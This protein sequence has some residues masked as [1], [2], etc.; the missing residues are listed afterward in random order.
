MH[1]GALTSRRAFL[2]GGVALAAS[3]V[4][5][6]I[7]Y[8]NDNAEVVPEEVYG[9]NEWLELGDAFK[10]STEVD[11]RGY[12]FMVTNLE[13]MTPNEYLQAYSRDGVTA[14]EGPDADT[15]CVL[16]LS[17]KVRNIGNEE[18]GIKGYLWKMVPEEQNNILFNLDDEL[19][20]HGFPEFGGG[21]AF[22]V[23][24]GEAVERVFP[25][26]DILGFEPFDPDEEG[27]VRNE[28]TS[29]TFRLA[30]TDLP[31]RKLFRLSI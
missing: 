23:E 30:M 22:S 15:R 14:L 31:V 26:S 25:F 18:G 29:S 28:V 13:V 9:F 17:L 6:R 3:A 27:L 8:V 5:L 4:G 19:M 1:G 11:T 16:A 21:M 20:Q 12:S 24:M 7:K 10:G 2:A